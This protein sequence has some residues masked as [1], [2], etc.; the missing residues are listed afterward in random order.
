[1]KGGR[2]D[3]DGDRDLRGR[4]GDAGRG[5]GRG[6]EDGDGEVE[7]DGAGVEGDEGLD[8]L[9]LVLDG[10]V[11]GSGRKQGGIE[12]IRGAAWDKGEMD[13]REGLA[14]GRGVESVDELVES[15]VSRAQNDSEGIC[16]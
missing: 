15:A 14:A 6:G 8:G 9:E 13:A 2:G 5:H 1:M 7:W 4:M 3:Y 10:V 16:L 12:R 11:G